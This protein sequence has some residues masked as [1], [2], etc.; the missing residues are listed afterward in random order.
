MPDLQSVFAF[1]SERAPASFLERGQHANL[2]FIRLEG[3]EGVAAI[4][5]R[6]RDMEEKERGYAA[7][8]RLA[9]AVP[10]EFFVHV[11]EGWALRAM[12]LDDILGE[13]RPSENPRR[14]E[15]L[16]VSGYERGG[17]ALFKVWR[18]EREPLRVT[19]MEMNPDARFDDRLAEI[20]LGLPF[21]TGLHLDERGRFT[22]D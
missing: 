10:V 20:L 1:V 13:L 4:E 22:V 17:G 9:A 8:G 3:Q 16:M 21:S 18:I 15:V 14:E 2:L 12:A 5:L 19:E 7:L 6:H 11:A